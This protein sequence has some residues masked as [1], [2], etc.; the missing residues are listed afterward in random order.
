MGTPP[1]AHIGLLSMMFLRQSVNLIK[2]QWITLTVLVLVAICAL[3]LVPLPKLPAAPGSDKLHH[4]VAYAALMFPTAL[5][6][7][8]HWLWIGLLFV[9]CSGAIEWIQPFVNRYGEW[10]DL[11]ANAA[12]VAIGAGIARA[13]DAL[14][15]TANPDVK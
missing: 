4:F 11:L 6:R 13:A 3:S 15:P 12:G 7:P 8:R 5:R 10:Q 14:I 1:V 2:S 9:A